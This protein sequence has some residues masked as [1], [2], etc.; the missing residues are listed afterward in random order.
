MVMSMLFRDPRDA[1]KAVRELK[2][3]GY[4]EQSIGLLAP[5]TEGGVFSNGKA[6]S[7][8]I[9]S[10]IAAG[11]MADALAQGGGLAEALS[12]ALEISEDT[13]EFY[14]FGI[15]SGA[16]LV[17]VHTDEA[18]AKQA[19]QILMQADSTPIK[20][21]PERSPGFAM[22]SRMTATNPIDAPMSGDFRKY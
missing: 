14:K 19:G 9:G 22:A 5:G 6:V 15:L 18:K 3:Q 11:P 7:V 20:G 1:E 4:G 17:T 12:K 21:G 13:G 16:V 2:A 10:V 8:D